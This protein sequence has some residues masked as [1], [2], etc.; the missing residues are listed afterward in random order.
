M[1]HDDF[2]IE[3]IRGLPEALPP[4]ETILW[5]GA[6]DWRA[7]ARDALLLRWVAGYFGVLIAWRALAEGPVSGWVAAVQHILPLLILGLLACGLIAALAFAQARATVYT[8]TNRRV[9]MRIGVALTLTLNLPF[10]QV[11]G[12]DLQLRKDGT[13]T[14]ALAMSGGKPPGYLVCWPHVRPWRMSRVEP[15]LRSIPRAAEVAALLADQLRRDGD[16][17]RPDAG[18]AV[19]AE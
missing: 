9:V 15:A 19:A 8:V 7:L 16:A 13:G 11:R 18:L 17:A 5:Q 4:G 1:P 14:I 12:A 6:P 2:H 3:P 10:S